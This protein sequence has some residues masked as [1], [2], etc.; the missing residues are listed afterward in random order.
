LEGYCFLLR[1]NFNP[2]ILS[3][4]IKGHMLTSGKNPDAAVRKERL[5]KGY[6]QLKRI[7]NF[8]P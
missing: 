3:Y 8:P 2:A 7:N 6:L 5:S 4:I 1:I